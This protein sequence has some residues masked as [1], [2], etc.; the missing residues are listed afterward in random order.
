LAPVG[1]RITQM[2]PTHHA[3]AIIDDSGVEILIHVSPDT[4]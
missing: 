1:G 4:V 2:H 3:L